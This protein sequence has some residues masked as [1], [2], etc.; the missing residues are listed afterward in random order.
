M[1]RFR[2]FAALTC[3][4]LAACQAGE[5]ITGGLG[6]LAIDATAAVVPPPAQN[7][8]V[9]A[10]VTNI[11]TNPLTINYSGC[12]V[13]PVFHSGS[14]DGPIVYDSRTGVEC[15]LILITKTLDPN[16]S[17][18]ITGGAVPN[19]PAGK[20]FVGAVITINGSAVTLGAGTVTF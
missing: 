16:Q 6:G 20:Y 9:T 18:Q 4:A 10:T 12:V 7:V 3:I 17:V 14:L 1:D 5:D 11:S 13:M 8:K 15:A 19:L 2:R